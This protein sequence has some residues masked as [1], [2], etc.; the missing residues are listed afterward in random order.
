MTTIT[1]SE[2]LERDLDYYIAERNKIQLDAEKKTP[3]IANMCWIKLGVANR[4]IER[5]IAG[6]TLTPAIGDE[7]AG[8]LER[9][10]EWL[11]KH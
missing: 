5:L 9:T 7:I 3:N 4:H 2:P 8:C 10:R 6:L 1:T 11:E